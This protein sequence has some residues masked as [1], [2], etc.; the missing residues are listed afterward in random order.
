MLMRD[1]D[2]CPLDRVMEARDA[3]FNDLRRI[4]GR[5]SVSQVFRTYDVLRKYA[6]GVA[7]MGE[8]LYRRNAERSLCC[9][10]VALGVGR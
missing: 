1:L 3:S 8:D 2:A 6:G 5:R 4:T 9:A 10:V 7:E